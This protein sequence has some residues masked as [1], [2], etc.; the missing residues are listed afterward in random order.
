MNDTLH[1]ALVF[2]AMI[3]FIASVFIVN[4]YCAKTPATKNKEVKKWKR[5]KSHNK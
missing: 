3:A 1:A 2:I 5:N 4:Y